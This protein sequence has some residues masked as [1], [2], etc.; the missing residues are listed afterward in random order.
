MALEQAVKAALAAVGEAKVAYT[1]THTQQA[2]SQKEVVGLLER[3]QS[4]S[5]GDL[6]RY[7]S[8]IRSEHIN[9]QAVQKSRDELTE[10]ERALE[11]AR[12]EL[13]KKERKQYHEE[14]IWSD[15]IR[16][17]STWVTFGLMGL[18]FVILLGNLAVIEPWRRRRLVR[19]VRRALEENSSTVIATAMLEDGTVV[20]TTEPN[21][22]STD[23]LKSEARD[24]P[25]STNLMPSPTLDS[26]ETVGQ[27]SLAVGEVLPQEAV[28]PAPAGIPAEP[29]VE[30]SKSEPFEQTVARTWEDVKDVT[31]DLFSE[32]QVV[33][34]KADLTT[35]V[36]EGAAAGVAIMG[37]LFV[38][39]RPG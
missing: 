7:M 31:Q 16:R 8:L 2:S 3:K 18:N 20:E 27:S 36:L 6:E 25:S 30:S 34:S 13:E 17:N 10:A 4:W 33:M 19:E 32:R 23:T 9:E 15:T 14:Q 37:F 26:A 28:D 38:V 21:V 35:L 12:A 29:S 1:T 5:A 39:L 22:I 11:D 24:E